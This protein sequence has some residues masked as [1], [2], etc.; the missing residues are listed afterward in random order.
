MIHLMYKS[1]PSLSNSQMTMDSERIPC[2]ELGDWRCGSEANT[3]IN[4]SDAD[5]GSFHAAIGLAFT[6][7]YPPLSSLTEGQLALLLFWGIVCR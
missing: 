3:S 4:L 7:P 6:Y 5:G 1:L 2:R